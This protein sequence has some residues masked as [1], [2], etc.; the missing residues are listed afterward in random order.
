MAERIWNEGQLAAITS[1]GGNILVSAAAGSGKTAVLVERV[2]RMLTDEHNPVDADRLLIVTFTR[3]A[4]AE[5]RSRINAKLSELSAQ[6]P[7]DLRLGRQLL[8]MERAHIGTIHSFCSEVVRENASTLGLMPDPSVSDEDEAADISASALEETIEKYYAEGSAEF[9]ELTETLGGGRNDSGL[10]DAVLELYRFI[11]SLP[12]YED[13]LSEKA[14][15]YDP[16]IP[17]GET[18]WGKILLSHAHSVL[19]YHIKKA[20]QL[21]EKCDEEFLDKLAELCR[22]D[23]SVLEGLLYYCELGR[24]DSFCAAVAGAAFDRMPSKHGADDYFKKYFQNTR[25]EYKNAVKKTLAKDFSVSEA[26]FREDIADLYPKI[27]CLF[28]VTIDYARRFGELKREKRLIDYTDLEQLTLSVLTERDEHGGY[29]PTDI[30][31]S[32]SERFDYILIDECQDINKVQDTIFKNI[33]RGDNL[34]FVG[35]VKQSIYRFRQAMPELFLEKRRE[36]PV[37]KDGKYPAT[38][39]LGKNYRSRKNIAGAVNYIFRQIMTAEAAEIEYDES[40]MLIPAAQF[41]EDG[42]CRNEVMLIE[43]LRDSTKAEAEAVADRIYNMVLRGE[44][45]FDGKETRPIR[46]SDICILFRA[47]KGKTEIFLSALRRRGISARSEKDKGFLSRPE[48]AAVI[49]VLKAVDNPLLDIPLAGAML[50]EM[51]LFTPDELAEIRAESRKIPLYSSVKLAAENGSEKAANFISVLDSLRKAAA[52]ERSDAVI[53]RLYDL[54][55]FPQVMRSCSEGKLKLANLRLLVKYAADREKAGAKGLSSFIRFITRLE[56]R[57]S[58]LK[59]SGSTGSGNCVRIMSVHGSKGLEFPVVFLCGTSKQFRTERS[60]QTM[61]HPDLGFACPRRDPET[62]ARFTTV[63]QLALMHELR[64]Y[65]LAE[66]MRILYVALTRPKERLIITCCQKDTEKY[67]AKLGADALCGERLDPFT[68]SSA[69][70]ESDWIL[71]A[72]LRHPDAADLRLLAGIDESAVVPDDTQW[73]FSTVGDVS[74]ENREESSA[75]EE[76][77][78]VDEELYRILKERENWK[79]PFSASEKIPA[80]AGVSSLTHQEMH[81]KMLFAAKP[82]NGALSGA[83]RGTALHTFMQFCDFAAAKANPKAET[84]R[85]A[86]KR[87]ISQKQAEVIDPLK[88]KAFFESDLYRRIENSPRVWRELRFLRG[89][90]AAELGY[91]GA[92]DEDKITVQGVADCVFEENGKLIVVDYKTDFVEDIEELRERYAAQLNMYKK[93][94]SESLG[95]EVVSAIIWSFRFG[96]ELE[97]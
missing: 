8:L 68:V 27:N 46:Y 15:M 73:S 64:R 36:W 26:E 45:V 3:L 86:E 72:L 67:L 79:Y 11:S 58:D 74:V 40:E 1:F 92:S 77:A 12:H 44:P 9:A 70:C 62:G 97:V 29:A 83:D 57:E 41:P 20:E 93:L 4:A 50:S 5:M 65:N 35:D 53:E 87:F 28:D 52:Y 37:L 56:E 63:P 18:V 21:A 38:I 89:L 59:P 61:L 95:K 33:S 31:K 7:K 23:I 22:K 48:V 51:F 25:D 60:D 14:A 66:E 84:A 78:P 82:R 94:L 76:T 2:I 69:R 90:S 54:T 16:S 81:R 43:S 34:F 42:I 91:E 75:E 39:I 17:V 30:A 32:I 49:D 80:K 85:L 10:S 88:V 55:A 71:T 13:W 19:S 6:N 24:W 47:A 96:K